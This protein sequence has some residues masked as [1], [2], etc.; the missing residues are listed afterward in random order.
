MKLVFPE[1]QPFPFRI[2]SIPLKLREKILVLDILN[3]DCE[4]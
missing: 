3:G 2:A 4:Y 1:I